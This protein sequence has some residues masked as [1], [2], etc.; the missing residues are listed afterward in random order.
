MFNEEAS[1]RAVFARFLESLSSQ[2]RSFELVAVND[3]SR[4]ATG[5]LLDEIAAREPRVRVIHFAR[6]FG[7]TAAMMAGFWASR[8]DVVVP[9]DGDGQNEPDEVQR[10]VD[11]LE[12][13]WDVVSGWRKDR[14]DSWLRTRVSRVANWIIGKI[15]G[16]RL[17]DYGC[18]LK[19]YRAHMVRDARLFGEMHRF[20]PIYTSMHGARIT[21]M[22]VKHHPRTAGE[23]KYGYGRIIKVALDIALVRML[24]KYRTKPLHFFGKI[25][26]YA[27]LGTLLCLVFAVCQSGFALAAGRGWEAAWHEFWGKAPLIGAVFFVLGWIA[28]MAGLVAELVM[29]AGFEFNQGRY[30]DELRRVNF[31]SPLTHG[32]PRTR[33]RGEVLVSASRVERESQQV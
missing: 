6:N 9:L 32:E 3:G 24:Q 20:I 23:S 21:E 10:L 12:E 16:V 7:Q 14:K 31:S 8:G 25:T 15:T 27:W 26:Q 13:G 29:R 33:D 5:A 17:H 4:D 1:V 19:A 18:T 22:V 11:K 28:I 2:R 30:W